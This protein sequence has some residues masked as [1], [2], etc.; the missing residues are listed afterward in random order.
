MARSE[1]CASHSLKL[2][3][4]G[5]GAAYA[6][7][8]VA[9]QDH[10]VAIARYA[11]RAATVSFTLDADATTGSQVRNTTDD[12]A[13]AEFGRVPPSSG[14]SK[15]RDAAAVVVDKK[16][17]VVRRQKSREAAARNGAA[18]SHLT[19]HMSDTLIGNRVILNEFPVLPVYRRHPIPLT[20]FTVTATAPGSTVIATAPGASLDNNL[21]LGG[22]AGR[23]IGQRPG[24]LKLHKRM[25]GPFL[26][27]FSISRPMTSGISLEVHATVTDSGADARRLQFPD[28]PGLTV[29]S[30]LVRDS[31]GPRLWRRRCASAGCRPSLYGSVD[32]NSAFRSAAASW[33]ER[34][35][36]PRFYFCAASHD[37]GLTTLDGPRRRRGHRR[38]KVK[39]KR[40]VPPKAQE[41]DFGKNQALSRATNPVSSATQCFFLVSILSGVR[42]LSDNYNNKGYNLRN[43]AS[44]TTRGSQASSTA[45]LVHDTLLASKQHRDR[46]QPVVEAL[47]SLPQ[48]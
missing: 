27:A 13:P 32:I 35:Y 23:D 38:E 24:G 26:L 37:G 3:A 48:L 10:L 18:D 19:N 42:D 33:D 7:I 9:V 16:A 1:C 25:R 30:G 47:R 20:A 12:S 14:A 28:A 5:G 2:G 44:C 43:S 6:V 8:V 45:T 29:E 46:S 34:T 17:T 21:G 11:W 41:D 31:T 15:A 36:S 39:R 22:R 40:D 4:G